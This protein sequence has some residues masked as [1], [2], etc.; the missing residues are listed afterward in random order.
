ML[1]PLAQALSA[2]GWK[3][4]ARVWFSMQGE[5]SA[6]VVRFPRSY[7]QLAPQL[8]AVVRVLQLIDVEAAGAD[9][10]APEPVTARKRGVVPPVP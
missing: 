5:M 4:K 8:K 9:S 2:A 3:P 6:T 10:R 1:Q 7:T